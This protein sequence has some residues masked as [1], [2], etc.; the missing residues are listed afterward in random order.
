MTPLKP[1]SE[2]GQALQG[3]LK[4]RIVFLDGAM[5]TMIQRRKLQEADQCG[6]SASKITLNRSRV[7]TTLLGSGRA[8]DVIKEIHKAYFEAGADIVETNTFS[9]TSIGIAEYGLSGN[10]IV[11]DMNVAAVRLAKEAAAEVMAKDPSRRLFVAALGPTTKHPFPFAQ[12]QP[13]R[14][15]RH[16]F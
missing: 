4:K 10:N 8:S 7:T 13:A 2:A 16:H 11:H 14:I 5:G 3:L 12:G 15:P 1:Y 9:A 6:V